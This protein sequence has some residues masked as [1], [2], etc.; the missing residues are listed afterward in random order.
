M[1]FKKYRKLPEVFE[2]AVIPDEKVIRTAWGIHF[3][4]AG[5]VLVRQKGVDIIVYPANQFTKL[6]TLVEDEHDE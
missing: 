6:F 4:D 3:A 5:D 2:A 1:E